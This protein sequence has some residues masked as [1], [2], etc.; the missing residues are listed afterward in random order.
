MNKHNVLYVFFKITLFANS[1]L[2]EVQN[3]LKG[4]PGG[5]QG[6]PRVPPRESQGISKVILGTPKGPLG[7]P[8]GALGSQ[9]GGVEPQGHP[10]EPQVTL[11]GTLKGSVT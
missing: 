1:S 3:D 8:R 6:G 7:P 5:A 11:K 10:K 2:R 4:D 9:G